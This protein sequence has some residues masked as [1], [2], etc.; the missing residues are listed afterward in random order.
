MGEDVGGK[1]GK[2]RREG[3]TAGEE[4]VESR[5]NNKKGR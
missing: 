3:G 1:G 4:S 5:V 2:G